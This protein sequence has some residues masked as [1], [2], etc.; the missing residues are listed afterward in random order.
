MEE[1][2]RVAS[3]CAL[4]DRIVKSSMRA[5]ISPGMPGFGQNVTLDQPSNGFSIPAPFPALRWGRLQLHGQATRVSSLMKF[6]GTL[7]I[8]YDGKTTISPAPARNSKLRW[9]GG[10]ASTPSS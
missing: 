1:T 2:F 9:K 6:G 3:A 7:W 10:C 8:A 4:Y 5:P